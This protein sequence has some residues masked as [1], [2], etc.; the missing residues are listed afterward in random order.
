MIKVTGAD[1]LSAKTTRIAS[2]LENPSGADRD[3]TSIFRGRYEA[4]FSSSG[5]GTWAPLSEETVRKKGSSEILVATGALQ[6]AM[7]GGDARAAAESITYQTDP[8]FYGVIVSA[9]RP[10]PPPADAELAEQITTALDA[11]VMGGA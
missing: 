5:D 1:D 8:P 7:V 10:V 6:A 2:R 4:R 11:Y 3:L 9:K